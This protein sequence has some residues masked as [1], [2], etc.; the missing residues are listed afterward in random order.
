MALFG[1]Q[2]TEDETPPLL[3]RES[4]EIRRVGREAYRWL[5]PRYIWYKKIRTAKPSAL[6]FLDGQNLEEQMRATRAALQ[7][8]ERTLNAGLVVAFN[9]TLKSLDKLEEKPEGLPAAVDMPDR[10]K[11]PR[12]NDE[13]DAVIITYMPLRFINLAKMAR[14]KGKGVDFYTEG[15]VKK[16]WFKVVGFYADPRN[17]KT[18]RLA[19]FFDGLAEDA[20]LAAINDRLAPLKT[21]LELFEASYLMFKFGTPPRRKEAGTANTLDEVF[22][23][24]VQQQVM[25]LYFQSVIH[26]GLTHFLFRYYVTLLAAMPNPKGMRLIS[27]IFRPVLA[28][29]DQVRIRFQ[30]S[31]AMERSKIGLRPQYQEFFKKMEAQPFV[32]EAERGGKK[33]QLHN[34]TH[35]LLEL[36]AFP[37]TGGFGGKQA[38][39]WRAFLAREVLGKAPLERGCAVLVELLDTILHSTQFAIDGKLE[40]VNDLRTFAEEQEQLSRQE[41]RKKEKAVADAKRKKL[42]SA[43]KFKSTEQFDM[44]KTI[45][46][47]AADLEEQGQKM[48]DAVEAA[49]EKRKT[50]LSERADSMEEAAKQESENHL[51]R[52]GAAVFAL[53]EEVDKEKKLH[54]AFV[55]YVL[56]QIQG[57]NDLIYLDFYKNLFS[58]VPGLYPTEKM[59]LR[60]AVSS[61][62][63]LEEGDMKVSAE[64]SQ[65]YEQQ[66]VTKKTELTMET[67]GILE[68]R[69]RH[70]TVNTTLDKVLNAGL[71]QASLALA[72]SLGASAPNKPVVKLPPPV[73]QKLLALN[74]LMHPF[75]EHD[76]SLPN[77]A[78]TEPPAKRVNFNRLQKLLE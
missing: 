53:A 34:Y 6:P 11:P 48:L 8:L 16:L 10:S 7:M 21:E 50:A 12:L 67:P 26:T 5:G 68:Q 64:E 56:A 78:E 32:T 46:Q 65:A 40:V 75:A 55:Q 62:T 45:E 28:K 71:T 19:Y 44:V 38:E 23:V 63:K 49:I 77:V 59:L 15:L 37:R 2:K 1:G 14:D 25:D 58:L 30:A 27:Q 22:D 72:L 43:R 42:A 70:N 20:D 69:F 17:W 9:S 29:A 60:E 66:I 13:N 24:S 76:I 35:R 57:D 3:E 54:Q 36:A 4:Q 39:H 73:V 74:Q 31:F 61:R 33:V 52:A 47:E 18:E 41:L 51:G